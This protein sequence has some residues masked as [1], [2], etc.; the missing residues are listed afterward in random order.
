[1][2]LMITGGGAPASVSA[3]E[4]EH[5]NPP[6]E[7]SS[8]RNDYNKAI[9]AVSPSISISPVGQV[10]ISPSS[11]G[12]VTLSHTFL[13]LHAGPAWSKDIL[14]SSSE[15]D[16]GAGVTGS[17]YVSV[18]PK[19]NVCVGMDFS[20]SLG[21]GASATATAGPAS[22]TVGKDADKD[23]ANAH[24]QVC[25]GPGAGR[26][27]FAAADGIATGV[28]DGL[29]A[30]VESVPAIMGFDNRL[31]AGL[32]EVLDSPAPAG[33]AATSAPAI[34]RVLAPLLDLF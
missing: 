22:G 9:S 11:D 12:G 16:V 18:T 24:I 17:G 13:S 1:M 23:I 31:R 3:H 7:G 26:D 2:S 10:D 27:L 34:E 19:D 6:A 25:T 32:G 15:A 33:A 5:D 21:A 28:T 20:E 29:R 4:S 30:V 14:G 8:T